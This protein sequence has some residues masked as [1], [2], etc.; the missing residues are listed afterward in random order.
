M[1]KP[2]KA[3]VLGLVAAS[4]TFST[5]PKATALISTADNEGIATTSVSNSPLLARNYR[6]VRVYRPRKPQVPRVRIYRP[7]TR[8]NRYRVCSYRYRYGNRVRVC[9]YYRRYSR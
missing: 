6:R 4:L 7:R 5:M 3:T 8:V 2:M 9:R 1:L